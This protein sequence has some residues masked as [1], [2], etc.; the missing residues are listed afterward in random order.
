[1]NTIQSIVL[2]AVQGITE[3]LPISSTGHILLV[4]ELFFKNM[5]TVFLLTI[6]Q[7]GSTIAI[8]V[9]FKE[10]IFKN[11][12][13]KKKWSLFAK[14]A[15]GSIPAIAV[16]LVF[17]DVIEK[18]F[19]TNIV[20]ALSL[21]LWGI[22]MIAVE[23]IKGLNKEKTKDIEQINYK[24]SFI[25][26]IAQ[27]F[28]IIPGTSRSGSTTVAG[29]LLGIEKY[30]AISFSFLLGLPVLIGSFAFEMFKQRDSLAGVIT[31]N[32]G[33]A[34]IISFVFGYLS[35]I[36]LR[37]ISKEKFLTY[38]GIYRLILGALILFLL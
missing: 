35:L 9:G 36:I 33:I 28:A 8:I 38:F 13:T 31:V 29:V 22:L 30:T 7:L 17:Q 2:A 34:I 24:Q 1:M 19:H 4:A 25:I 5:P 15:L 6:L 12:F 23:N 16:A 27:A 11:F 32:N 21:I 37:K 18:Y 10:I 3:L 14:I 26:G 20:I